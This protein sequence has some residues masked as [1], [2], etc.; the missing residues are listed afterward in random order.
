ME[1]SGSVALVTGANRGL[2]RAFARALVDAGAAKVYAGAR[3]VTS[4]TDPGVTAVELDVT[5]EASVARAA[6]QLGDV[7]ILVNNAGIALPGSPLA[8]DALESA[9][10][11]LEVNYLGTLAVS[12]AFAPVLG[13]NGGGALVNMLSVL[14]WLAHPAIGGYSASKSAQWS[15]TNALRTHLAPQG[16]LVVGVH[17]GW[18]DTDMAAGIDQPKVAPEDVAAALIEGL[19][20]GAEEVLV[21]DVARS[22]KAALPQDLE[23]L[24]PG[25]RAKFEAELAAGAA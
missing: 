19:L 8:D 4:V 25:V 22:V 1:I 21:D 9:R 7:S 12:R 16:T 18:I 5:D 10:R 24:Y 13:R 15:L 6:E 17:A 20:A 23:V 11:E 3:D 14:S 2:G